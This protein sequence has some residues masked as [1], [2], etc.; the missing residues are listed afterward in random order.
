MAR[1]VNKAILIGRLGQDPDLRQTG[2]GTSVCNMRLATDESYTDRDGNE[3]ER[4]EWHDVVAFGRLAEVCGEY[5]QKGSQVYIEGSLQTSEY[6]DRDGVERSSTEIKA[7]N[8][9]FL[10]RGPGGAP[11]G[12]GAGRRSSQ[13]SSAQGGP[14]RGEP[15]GGG[16]SGGGPSGGG[17]SGGGPSSGG[18]SGG[19]AFE[20]DDDLPF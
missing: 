11:G 19:D 1:S 18:G 7:R 6:T 5:L 13:G 4:T 8:A 3:V 2:S 17:P 9:Q 20:P 16:P 10:G 12:G 14:S 15:S